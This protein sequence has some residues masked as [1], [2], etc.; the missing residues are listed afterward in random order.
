M[1]K[2]RNKLDKEI[3]RLINRPAE[4]GHI[5]EYIAARIF[6]IALHKS[7]TQKGSDGTF[8]EGLL[9]GKNVNVKWYPLNEL[10]LD[11]RENR[12]PDF[13]LVLTGQTSK[14][15]SSMGKCR[16]L[17]IDSVFLFD[18]HKLVDTLRSLGK[19]IYDNAPTNLSMSFWN[20]AEFYPNQ[21]SKMLTLTEEQTKILSLFHS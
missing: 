7:A 8:S 3:C 20:E 19:R 17:V 2:N 5:G 15:E 6:R 13:Y 4:K 1:L 11:I 9:K 12:L 10:M 16:P 18:A 21:R 14:L